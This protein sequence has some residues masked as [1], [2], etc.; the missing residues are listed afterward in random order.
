MSGSH[1]R[2]KYIKVFVT[3]TVLT[4]IE[5]AVAIMLKQQ[6][7]LMI[8]LL[9]GLAVAKASAVALYF[10]HLADERRGLKLA[11]SLPMLFPPFAAAI[12]MLE[13]IARFSR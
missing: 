11:V 2:K 4:G 9:I 3:L 8:A 7:G 1:D 13:A 5:I 10:M 6:R 12:L